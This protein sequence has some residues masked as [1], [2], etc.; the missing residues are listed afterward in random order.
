[1][2]VAL[3][4]GGRDTGFL[5]IGC[6]ALFYAITHTHCMQRGESIKEEREREANG[7]EGGI[8]TAAAALLL[9]SRHCTPVA[10]FVHSMNE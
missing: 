9:R 2:V 1:M 4:A 8:K 10:F 3:Q 5:G 6:G 7:R